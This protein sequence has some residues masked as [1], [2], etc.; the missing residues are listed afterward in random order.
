MEQLLKHRVIAPFIFIFATNQKIMT[1]FRFISTAIISLGFLFPSL[2]YSQ[3]GISVSPPRTYFTVNAGMT[4]T[5]KI[6]VS[7][8]SKTNT[9]E[10]SVSLN[11]WEYDEVGNNVIMDAGESNTSS[12]AWISILPQS[13]FS[14]PPGE[15]Y[16]LDVQLN[17]PVDADQS[18]PVHTSMLYI[19]QINPT[20][21]IDEQGAN[22]KIAVRSGVKIYHRYDVKREPVIEVSNFAYSKANHP[23]KLKISFANE[24]NVWTDG[25]IICELLN[26]NTG[27]KIKLQDAIFYTMPGNNRDLFLQ[28]PENMVSAPYIASAI[29]DYEG[30]A[31]VKL[32]ELSF[33]YD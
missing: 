7:N 20:D 6:L 31:A 8:P 9:L 30:A 22:I 29:I 14:L 23:D 17:V 15:S 12:A 13:F 4:E 24:G 1:L 32:A 16:E 2:V 11:D 5:K 10:L 26:Q 19:T 33:S 3:T 28:L 21:G 25:T 18:I 27:E